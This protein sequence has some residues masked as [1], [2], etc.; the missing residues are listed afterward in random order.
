MARDVLYFLGA[1]IEA[2]LPLVGPAGNVTA[3][4][5]ALSYHGRFDVVVVSDAAACP[6]VN[7]LVAGMERAG[8]IPMCAGGDELGIAAPE[9]GPGRTPGSGG[10]SVPWPASGRSYARIRR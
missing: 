1:R 7:L 4:F 3:V 9:P 2:V 10:P 8:A 6:D 5:A